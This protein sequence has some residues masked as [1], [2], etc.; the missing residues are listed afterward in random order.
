MFLM[1]KILN[2]VN[3]FRDSSKEIGDKKDS[4]DSTK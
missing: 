1:Q 3:G 4:L 2:I